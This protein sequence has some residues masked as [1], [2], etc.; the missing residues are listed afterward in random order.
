VF[1][2]VLI[3]MPASHP[4]YVTPGST[5]ELC[6]NPDCRKSVWVAPSG[7]RILQDQPEVKILCTICAFAQISK[8]GGETQEL[9]PEQEAEIDQYRRRN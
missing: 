1:K 9:N 7:R 8:V 4:G 5:K 2:N 6:S 3:C